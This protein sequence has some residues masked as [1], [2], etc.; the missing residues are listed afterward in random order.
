[1]RIR[2]RGNPCW[3]LR[4]CPGWVGRAFG[5]VCLGQFNSCP[6]L[7]HL[8]PARR[9]LEASAAG[10]ALDLTAREPPAPT[11]EGASEPNDAAPGPGGPRG[12][13]AQEVEQGGA[14]ER[15]AAR[16]RGRT[17]EE[18][19]GEEGCAEG[20]PRPLTARGGHSQQQEPGPQPRPPLMG[21]KLAEAAGAQDHN[22]LPR[23]GKSFQA[24][25]DPRPPPQGPDREGQ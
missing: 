21:F 8:N 4:H 25:G 17:L 9:A 24:P 19:E 5:R 3:G 10:L 11:P 16:R 6:C 7:P 1:M 23:G 12:G 20:R 15:R 14:A 13:G 2:V 18:E 22:C